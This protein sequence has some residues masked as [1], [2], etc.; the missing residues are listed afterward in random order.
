VTHRKW[1]QPTRAE[2]GA[3]YGRAVWSD[4]I[5]GESLRATEYGPAF[6][7]SSRVV[8][9][10]NDASGI[11]LTVVEGPGTGT[12]GTAKDFPAAMAALLVGTDGEGGIAGTKCADGYITMQDSCPGCD[13][14]EEEFEN[15][16][17]IKR[18]VPGDD[19]KIRNGQFRLELAVREMKAPKNHRPTQIA[20]EPMQITFEQAAGF[21]LDGQG[22]VRRP[23][24][25]DRLRRNLEDLGGV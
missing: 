4:L 2:S 13:A 10:V 20:P 6:A 25:Y 19:G 11:C 21:L 7:Y 8:S 24:D 9:V 18:P 22:P 12:T 16:H 15:K 1:K 23:I 3:L 5:D 17:P 14:F